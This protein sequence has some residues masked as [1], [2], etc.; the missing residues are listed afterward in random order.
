MSNGRDMSSTEILTAAA[1]QA[2]GLRYDSDEASEILD[3][4]EADWASHWPMIDGNGKLTGNVVETDGWTEDH[5]NVGDSAAIMRDD[6]TAAGWRIDNEGYAFEPKRAPETTDRLVHGR[7]YITDRG[8]LADIYVLAKNAAEAPITIAT[9]VRIARAW[10][11]VAAVNA[12]DALVEACR[13]AE[14]AM[15]YGSPTPDNGYYGAQQWAEAI[16]FIRDALAL[17]RGE[18]KP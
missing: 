17:V 7:L 14:T 16:Q 13:I 2:A 9:D 1:V 11:I 8:K 10:Q 3:A 12:H 6:A 5:L 18:V 15:G 4:A